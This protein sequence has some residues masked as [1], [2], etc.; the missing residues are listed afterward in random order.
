[1]PFLPSGFRALKFGYKKEYLALYVHLKEPISVTGF[2][3]GAIMPAILLGILPMVVGLLYGYLSVVL[4]GMFLTT[5][6]VGD[7]IL[8]AKTMRL[9]SGYMIKDQPDDIAVL[10][11]EKSRS[12]EVA[13]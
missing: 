12:E 10:A 11:I 9:H 1:M 6:A 5:G 2:R 8:L 4:F 3:I 13:V 7:F